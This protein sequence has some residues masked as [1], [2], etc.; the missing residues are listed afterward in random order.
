MH[1]VT[2]GGVLGAAWELG[3]ANHCAVEI[4]S[5]ERF[6]FARKRGKSAQF[7][8]SIHSV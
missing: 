1:D 6:P 7:W 3:Y 2:E 5:V 4:D 8:G